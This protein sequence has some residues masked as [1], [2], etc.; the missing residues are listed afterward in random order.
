MVM[1]E[2]DFSKVIF[3]VQVQGLPLEYISVRSAK[4]ILK[5]A[6]KV[7]EVEDPHVKGKLIRNSIRA[8]VEVN[9]RH[10]LFAGCWVSRR[11]LPRV[12]VFVKYERL[13]DLCF[14][15]GIIGHEQKP[16]VNQCVMSSIG[17][18]VQKY[19]PR[20]GTP[21]AKTIKM[22]VEE[23]ERRRKF[24]QGRNKQESETQSQE[25]NPRNEAE[26]RRKAAETQLN[27]ERWEYEGVLEALEGDGKLPAGWFEDYS[28][29]SRSSLTL[30]ASRVYMPNVIAQPMFTNL[31]L[32]KEFPGFRVDNGLVVEE[33]S[34]PEEAEKDGVG[35][36]AQS[37]LNPG[38]HCSVTRDLSQIPRLVGI[39]EIGTA[40]QWGKVMDQRILKA[41]LIS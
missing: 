29:D 38:A 21:L 24:A 14:K 15:C 10:H 40:E 28:G 39:I 19:G 37:D 34:S 2:I 22:I 32:H 41:L 8:R 30:G 11:N 35:N 9:I 18:D 33:V 5:Q 31:H 27:K 12:W 36:S 6:G 3:W 26:E 17:K 20:V 1:K 25:G 23:Q 13:Q 7:L 16:C 4:K